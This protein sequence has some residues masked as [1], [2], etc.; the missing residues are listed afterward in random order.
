M[1]EN[2]RSIRVMEKLGMKRD[3]NGDFAHPILPLDHPLSKHVLYRIDR[4]R[5]C[6]LSS[7]EG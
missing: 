6:F 5:Y 2:V 7:R 1:P 3:V 4:R